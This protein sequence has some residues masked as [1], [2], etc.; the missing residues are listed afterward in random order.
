[1]RI[2]H[3]KSAFRGCDRPL[4][5]FFTH[6]G[7]GLD[8]CLIAVMVSESVMRSLELA[9]YPRTGG[10]LDAIVRCG[11]APS[12]GVTARSMRVPSLPART[13]RT[14]LRGQL[15]GSLQT[16]GSRAKAYAPPPIPRAGRFPAR[17][18]AEG[19]RQARSPEPAARSRGPSRRH[20]PAA[21][22]AAPPQQPPP[23]PDS[24]PPDRR[25]DRGHRPR[26]GGAQGSP[27]GRAEV[28]A[29]PGCYLVAQTTRPLIAQ[30]V[31]PRRSLARAVSP[32][33]RRR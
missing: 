9:P 30:A 33:A 2:C 1:M 20:T 5:G 18:Q 21:P 26:R 32:R 14:I 24:E 23:P 8:I 16:R 22:A 17:A 15:P 11:I 12:S 10:A 28:G 25:P 4:N 29:E 19:Q 13:S 31:S 7:L 6:S 27:S 3:G